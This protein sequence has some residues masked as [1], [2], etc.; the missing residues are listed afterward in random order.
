MYTL[1]RKLAVVC[2]AVVLSVL[3]YGCGGGS[4]KET[5][6]MPTTDTGG[7]DT[8][9]T[10]HTVDTTTNVS[11]G[12]TITPGTFTIQSGYTAD[13]G[14]VTYECPADDGL[15]CD[16]TATA[17]GVTSVGGAATAMNS[18]VGQAKADEA[19]KLVENER[20][21]EMRLAALR[22]VINDVNTDSVLVGLTITP[23][24]YNIDQGETAD[25]GDA[26]LRCLSGE[27]AC[28][29]TVAADGTVKSVGGAAT[30][31]VSIEG[32][33]KL[34][35]VREVNIELAPRYVTIPE[36][37]DEIQPNGYLQTG[38]VKFKC[39]KDGVRCI[40]EVD[41]EGAVTSA[42]GLVTVEGYSDD[43]IETRT[44]IALYSRNAD[45]DANVGALEVQATNAAPVDPIGVERNPSGVLKITPEHS[46]ST[47]E[48]SYTEA[49]DAGYGINKWMYQTFER[50]NG[51]EAMMD[52]DAEDP[53]WKDEATVY[54]NIDKAKEGKW[55]LTGMKS[56]TNP[57]GVPL[58]TEMA[59]EVDAG[60]VD[61]EGAIDSV[62]DDTF[63]GAYI[64]EDTTRIPGT[65]TCGIANCLDVAT[66]PSIEG[67]YLV[68]NTTLNDADWTFESK[69]NV[70]EGDVPDSDYM[71]FG[72]WLN[73]PAEHDSDSDTDPTDYA[74]KAFFGGNELFI[75]DSA[76]TTNNT[77][78][79]TKKATY[80]GGAAGRYVVTRELRVKDGDVDPLS[81]SF[82]GR[83]TAKAVLTAYYGENA[84]FRDDDNNVL[85][86]M[87]GGTIT[88]FKEGGTK[89]GFEVDLG[90]TEI[91]ST[92]NNAVATA[93]FATFG[94]TNDADGEDGTEGTWSAKTYGPNDADKVN[95]T[96]PT[97]IAGEFEVGSDNNKIVGAFAAE[98][99]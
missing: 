73:E 13:V 79:N 62:Q 30:A 87:I 55:K 15:A 60:Q 26:T 69:N 72:Y 20:L 94:E 7:M 58:I 84:A 2:L 67:N 96:F 50:N 29:V 6:E 85:D 18:A 9:M 99:K 41:D 86:N 14:D 23:D 77:T 5:A 37:R 75:V 21:E 95:T 33:V 44:A 16:V 11:P 4:S 90:M 40:V 53:T 31:E 98:E 48:I 70:P 81:P 19:A 42:G 59:F 1:T 78:A 24:V 93:T 52:V 36:G 12:L 27:V 82:H 43:A 28:I 76:I 89:L 39:P 49:V 25:A 38:D 10:P 46:D 56:E 61:E 80:E 63:T 35:T 64:R 83:F 66:R 34:H 88:D 8:V 71:Y 91:N 45:D 22:A 32:I 17:D 57:N 68:L 51:V 65:F 92:I 97:G 47:A 54:T 74:F 3:T